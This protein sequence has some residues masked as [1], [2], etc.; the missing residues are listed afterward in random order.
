MLL[1]AEIGLICSHIL[2]PASHSLLTTTDR[3]VPLF[4]RERMQCFAEGKG[5]FTLH[6]SSQTRSF[7][8]E[9]QISFS[10]K[11]LR[12]LNT[13]AAGPKILA[14][15]AADQHEVLREPC[16]LCLPE[17]QALSRRIYITG[18]VSSGRIM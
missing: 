13:K 17:E 10:V 7:L 5:R 18:Y 6:R 14:S 1:N 11:E 8:L 2:H 12:E 4:R 15:G 3:S 9:Y 16:V